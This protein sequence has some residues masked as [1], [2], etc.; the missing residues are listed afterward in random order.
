MR[1]ARRLYTAIAMAVV[2][3]LLVPGVATPKAPKKK[4]KVDISVR[5]AVVGTSGNSN[6]VAGALSGPPTGAGAVV[7]RSTPSGSDIAAKYTAFYKKGTVRGTSL[8]TPAPQPD[9]TVSFSGTLQIKGGTG[10]YRGAKGKDLKVT[11]AL[12]NNLITFHITGSVR[13]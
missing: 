6:I 10:K 8:L 13:Y 9:G 7:Y 4:H 12:A 11:G 2:V 3:A 1:G 5:A